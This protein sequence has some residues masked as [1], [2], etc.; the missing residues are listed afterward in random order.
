ML[1]FFMITQA[2]R[3]DRNSGKALDR[4]RRE[5]LPSFIRFLRCRSVLRSRSRG[6]EGHAIHHSQ[7]DARTRSLA[8]SGTG[9]LL[10]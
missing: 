7:L 10:T 9:T 6:R 1:K 4:P 5:F 2:T 8:P 3:T